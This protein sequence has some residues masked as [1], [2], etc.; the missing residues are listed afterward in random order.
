MY[1]SCP[2]MLNLERS[3]TAAATRKTAPLAEISIS[4]PNPS[5]T[6]AVALGETLV[7]PSRLSPSRSSSSHEY[8]IPMRSSLNTEK[9]NT[10]VPGAKNVDVASSLRAS[11]AANI[12]REAAARKNTP[13][14][15]LP[16]R[17][18]SS[19]LVFTQSAADNKRTTS[20]EVEASRAPKGFVEA[21]RAPKDFVEKTSPPPSTT[22]NFSDPPPPSLSLSSVTTAETRPALPRLVSFLDSN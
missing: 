9:P 8:E 2:P 1:F 17:A 10:S 19:R 11:L 16:V 13:P 5:A 12:A 3:S 14:A 20:S 7:S 4:S 21:S 18:N 6:Q 22:Q 15:S